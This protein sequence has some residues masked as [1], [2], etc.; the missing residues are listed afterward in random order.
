MFK[1]NLGFYFWADIEF[2]RNGEN[3]RPKKAIKMIGTKK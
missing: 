2:G 3:N 1:L